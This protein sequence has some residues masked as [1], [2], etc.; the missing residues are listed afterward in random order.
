MLNNKSYQ[1]DKRQ[2]VLEGAGAVVV[3]KDSVNPENDPSGVVIE[4]QT[5]FSC[6]SSMVLL[7]YYL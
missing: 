3:K 4:Q 7:Y 6:V 5:H 2:R 1:S